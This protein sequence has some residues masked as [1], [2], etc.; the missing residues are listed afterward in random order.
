MQNKME[1]IYTLK[2]DGTQIRYIR[3]ALRLLE[4]AMYEDPGKYFINCNGVN[5]IDAIGKVVEENIETVI[6]QINKKLH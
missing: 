2:V 5:K 6:T 4:D 1:D 3:A